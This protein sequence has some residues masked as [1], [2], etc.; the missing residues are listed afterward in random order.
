[1]ALN[2]SVLFGILPAKLLSMYGHKKTIILGGLFL[3]GAHVLA[4]FMLSSNRPND[5]LTTFLLFAVA[6]LGGQGACIIFL[7]TLYFQLRYHSIIC[8][9]LVNLKFNNFF[10]VKWAFILIFL[11]KWHISCRSQVWSIWRSLTEQVSS[12]HCCIWSPS[13]HF[14]RS[15]LHNER[16]SS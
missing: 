1:M 4:A 16:Q 2:A 10:L 15:D 7:S 12:H 3:T 14:S 9:H 6:V 8:T 13:L 11:R 5:T